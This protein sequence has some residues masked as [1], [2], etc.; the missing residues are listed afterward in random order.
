MSAANLAQMTA[1]NLAHLMAVQLVFHWDWR[2]EMQ[3]A[4]EKESKEFVML[5]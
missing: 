2:K 3:S 4:E 5:A 1:M